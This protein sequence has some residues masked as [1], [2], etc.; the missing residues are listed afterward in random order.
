MVIAGA[1]DARGIANG[2]LGARAMVAFLILATF[3][4][5]SG[6]VSV[7][8]A[9]GVLGSVLYIMQSRARR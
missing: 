8:M 7:A 6:L 9:W 4:A 2:F 3:L 1:R 5:L